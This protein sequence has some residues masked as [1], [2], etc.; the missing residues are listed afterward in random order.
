MANKDVKDLVKQAQEY[1]KSLNLN[2]TFR[3]I[4]YIVNREG[5]TLNQIRGAVF[6]VNGTLQ[7]DIERSAK[8]L[9]SAG[10]INPA[11][12]SP[13]DYKAIQNRADE[14]C[15]EWRENFGYIGVLQIMLVDVMEKKHFFIGKSDADLLSYL[16]EEGMQTD[17]IKTLMAVTL[18]S[19]A[20]QTEALTS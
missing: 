14:I 2:W 7:H 8:L 20:H 10:L 16:H 5:Y 1:I 19:K 9:L 13:D 18:D 11:T 15:E 17:L 3:S 6:D 12:V 4:E